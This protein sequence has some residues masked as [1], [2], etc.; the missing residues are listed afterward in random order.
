MVASNGAAATAP[1]ANLTTAALQSVVAVALSQWLPTGVSGSLA[2]RLHGVTFVVAD[3]PTGYLA[4][5]AG[6]TIY[7]DA[8][9]AGRGWFVDPTPTTDEEFAA[10]AG[11]TSLRAIDPARS[12]ASTC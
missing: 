7:V 2:E 5:T 9:A 12:T 1:A 10:A 3:L 4:L 8:D 11:G 6:T